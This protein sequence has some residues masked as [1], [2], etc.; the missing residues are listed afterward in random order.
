MQELTRPIVLVNCSG[1]KRSGL[2]RPP[3]LEAS[4]SVTNWFISGLSKK[5]VPAVDLY[6]GRSFQLARQAADL[7]T[8]DI[9][10]VSAGLG[11]V[12]GGTTI[13]WYEAT[14]S[15]SGSIAKRFDKQPREWW[16]LLQNESPYA[17]SWPPSERLLL[18]AVS[19]PYLQMIVEDLAIHPTENLRIFTRACPKTVPPSI[20]CALMPYGRSFDGPESPIPG[21]MTDFASRALYHFTQSIFNV[22]P[23]AGLDE[24]RRMVSALMDQWSPPVR[25]VGRTATDQ[26]IIA[27]IGGRASDVEWRASRMLRLLRDELGVACEQKR[28]GKLFHLALMN[29]GKAECLGL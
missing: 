17:S 23:K 16:R 9:M 8:A 12:S 11:L 21:T 14:V 6:V 25:R 15:G 10:I 22:A 29:K 28:F 18:V 24:H 5:G 4:P 27:L 2:D 1:R 20:R 3:S 7:A 26:E 13:P 19:S